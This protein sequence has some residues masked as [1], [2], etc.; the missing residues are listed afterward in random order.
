M[1]VLLA[2]F[3]YYDARLYGEV[4]LYLFYFVLQLYGW[5]YWLRGVEQTQPPVTRLTRREWVRWLFV[6]LAGGWV[7]AQTLGHYTDSDV[8]F[9]DGFTTSASVVAQLLMAHK[10]RDCWLW[11]VVVDIAYIGLYHFKGLDWFAALSA[12]YVVLALKGWFD[13]GHRD[14]TSQRREGGGSETFS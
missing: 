6:F 8:P 7:L 11:W 3:V 12:V 13:W 1:A 4:G 9:A 5:S 2:S 14:E 10:S